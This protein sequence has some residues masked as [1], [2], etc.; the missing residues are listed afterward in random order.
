MNSSPEIQTLYKG[1][2]LKF[3]TIGKWEYAARTQAS[4]V[5]CILAITPQDEVILVEQ[6]RPAVQSRVIELPAGLV[7]DTSSY[8]GE[9]N[10]AAAKRE[11]L[12]E[13]GYTAG[14][15]K[16]LAVGPSSAGMTDEMINFYLAT[17]LVQ[18]GP[19]LGDGHEELQQHIIPRNELKAWLK[20]QASEG[21]MIDYKTYAALCLAE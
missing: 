4:G 15:W 9:P 19:A 17:D 2:H 10:L 6:F 13:T 5:V 16:F 1:K 8:T 11:L 20:D 21:K 12:E 14:T 18:K 3:N 7:G